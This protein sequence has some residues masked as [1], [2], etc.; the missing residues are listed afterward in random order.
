MDQHGDSSLTIVGLIAAA[1]IVL[2]AAVV[3]SMWGCPQYSVYEQRLAGEAELQRATFNRQIAVQEANAKKESAK[4][5]AEAD[6]LRA[7]GAARANVILGN[8]LKGNEDYLRYLWIQ[9][10]ENGKNSPTVIYVPT[11]AGLPI[12]EAG[13]RPVRDK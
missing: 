13:R 2:L 7:E 3:L 9:G 5:L 6:V 12:L 1:G 11:E 10:L 8:S 4:A